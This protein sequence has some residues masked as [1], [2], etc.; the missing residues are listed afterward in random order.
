VNDGLYGSFN[1][2]LYD[3]VTCAPA[4]VLADRELNAAAAADDAIARISADATTVTVTDA[5]GLSHAAD[6][7]AAA[8]ERAVV[9][10][11]EA[12]ADED[13]EE[14]RNALVM[15]GDGSGV[16]G[17]ESASSGAGGAGSSSVGF[18]AAGS[19]A[20]AASMAGSLARAAVAR[21]ATVAA[22]PSTMASPAAG[23][24]VRTPASP[25]ASVGAPSRA[26]GYA[27]LPAA[28]VGLPGGVPAL[29]GA[30]H[31]TTLW[32]P[33]CDSMD[34]ISDAVA[35]PELQPGD[36]LVFENMGAYTVAGSCRFN[37]FPIASK[38]Y[39][40]TDGSVEVQREEVVE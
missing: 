5:V 3:H 20:A 2:I 7:A 33:T 17:G 12:A 8:V 23:G 32:G 36:W 35:M 1:C 26:F 28:T 13:A 15:G 21:S 18:S 10:A 9:R 37:G 19:V 38:V 22:T 34:K 25:A 27:A 30:T 6:L 16:V 14:Q 39:L 40:H 31:P 11:A 24:R 4:L 29:A